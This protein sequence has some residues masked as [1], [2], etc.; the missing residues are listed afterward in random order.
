MFINFSSLSP[1]FVSPSVAVYPLFFITIN[2]PLFAWRDPELPPEQSRVWLLSRRYSQFSNW[3]G[4]RDVLERWYEGIIREDP[5]RSSLSAVPVSAVSLT[6]TCVFPRLWGNWFRMLD[7]WY[8]N[9]W[10]EMWSHVI[11]FLHGTPRL[12]NKLYAFSAIWGKF[13]G[14][15][16]QRK[17][18]NILLN[19]E[20]YVDLVT[21]WDTNVFLYDFVWNLIFYF[22]L[23]Y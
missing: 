8:G 4:S 5:L 17:K 6:R 16:S 20:R 11:L 7:H 15:Q 19:A 2:E 23:W 13:R 10:L 9:I 18:R 21:L 3:K 22:Y 1:P 14:N 12:F